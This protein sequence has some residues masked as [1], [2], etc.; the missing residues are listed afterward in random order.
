[1]AEKKTGTAVATPKNTAIANTHDY[2]E[3][4]GSGQED[5]DSTHVAVPFMNLLQAMSP[6][7]LE[8]NPEGARAG[9]I[10]NSVTQELLKEFLINPSAIEHCYVEWIPKDKGGGFVAVHDLKSDVVVSAKERA[11]DRNKLRTPDGNELVETFYMYGAISDMDETL[12]GP[13]IIAFTSTKIKVYKGWSTLFN[14]FPHKKAGY[15]RPPPLFAHTI[16]IGSAMQKNAKGQFANFTARPFKDTL[17]ASLI[18]PT[19]PRFVAAAQL[20]EMVKAGLAKA[21][22]ETQDAAGA[23]AGEPDEDKVPF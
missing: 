22:Y 21:A 15:D 1:M 9:L 18:E 17:A 19:D 12:L 14:L 16:H 6:Q 8:N 4:S 13:G 11:T 2:G 23:E 7:V 20:R 3:F 5:M 10:L